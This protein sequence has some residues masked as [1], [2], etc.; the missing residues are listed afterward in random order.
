VPPL[1]GV[2]S[3]KVPRLRSAAHVSEA[4]GAGGRAEAAAVIGDVQGDQPVPE[5]QG[6]ADGGGVGVA[7]AVGQDLAGDGE[8]VVGQC[9]VRAGVQRAGEADAGGESELRGVLLDDLQEPGGQPGGGLAGLVEPEDAGADLRDDL[10]EGVDVAGDPL[11]GGRVG[12]GGVALGPHAEGEQFLD[13]MVV[14]VAR[15]PVVVFCLGQG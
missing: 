1:A 2:V 7:G 11:R 12:A 4:A 3:W 14:Q 10:V 9:L 15:D 6:D 5:D 8:D 13:D